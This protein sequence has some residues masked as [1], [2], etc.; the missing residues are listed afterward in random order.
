MI[1][2]VYLHFLWERRKLYLTPLLLTWLL[3]GSRTVAK[4]VYVDKSVSGTVHDGSSW[5]TAFASLQAGVNVCRS[6]DEVWVAAPKQSFSPYVGTFFINP[7]VALYGGFIGNESARVQRDWKRN[8]TDLSGNGADAVTVQRLGVLLDGFTIR[9]GGYGVVVT[10]GSATIRNSIF[11]GN[12]IG[13]CA[14]SG[15]VVTVVNCTSGWNRGSGVYVDGGTVD[16]ANSCIRNNSDHGVFVNS[17]T[18]NIS[19]CT[20]FANS[21][22]GVS[23]YNGVANITNCTISSSAFG[24]YVHFGTATLTNCAVA[25]N[26]VGIYAESVLNNVV[27]FNNDVVANTLENYSAMSDP[28]GYGGNISADPRFVDP[29]HHDYHLAPESPCRDAGTDALITPGQ[30]DLDGNP[31][32]IGAHVDIGAFEFAIPGHYAIADAARA[33][34]MSAGLEA[35]PADISRWDVTPSSSGVG[36]SD[37]VE[38]ARKA[39]GLAATP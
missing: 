3:L 16:C 9:D 37:V 35:A 23:L 10:N 5:A 24:V 1:A 12:G 30:T 27:I 6:G 25:N 17:G 4:V 36:L 8:V 31:R 20:I 11:D 29:G 34:R 13:V 33:L 14:G 21:L 26:S 18:A 38:I 15:G 7:G 32:K 2:I 28:T 19:N 22:R 39:S